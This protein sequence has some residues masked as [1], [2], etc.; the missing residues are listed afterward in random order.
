M[1]E[2]PGHWRRGLGSEHGAGSVLQGRPCCLGFAMCWLVWRGIECPG[3]SLAAIAVNEDGQLW[4][5]ACQT[6]DVVDVPWVLDLASV[7]R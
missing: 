5:K 3:C 7:Q 2:H 6:A 1:M 4:M